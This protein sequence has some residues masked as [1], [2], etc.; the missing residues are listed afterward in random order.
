MKFFKFQTQG[1][2]HENEVYSLVTPNLQEIA[3]IAIKQVASRS[4][5]NTWLMYSQNRLFTITEYID[6]DG[7]HYQWKS[8]VCDYCVIP[9]ADSILKS[10]M[11]EDS[12][13]IV[14]LHMI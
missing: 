2:M 4:L 7:A 1:S 14:K 6:L 11:E 13:P 12:Y 5:F 10:C 9:E 8:V 3:A